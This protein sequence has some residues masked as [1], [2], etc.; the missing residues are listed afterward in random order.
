M[1]SDVA[2]FVFANAVLGSGSKRKV[3]TLL[4]DSEM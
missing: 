3:D 1:G 4:S 2:A